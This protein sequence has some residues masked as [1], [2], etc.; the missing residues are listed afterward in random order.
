MDEIDSYIIIITCRHGLPLLK[1]ECADAAV[2]GKS[3]PFRFDEKKKLK[4][5]LDPAGLRGAVEKL[6]K[7]SKS[8]CFPW[9]RCNPTL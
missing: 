5:V 9:K 7:H 3:E 2:A 4:K 8:L 6:L 1:P